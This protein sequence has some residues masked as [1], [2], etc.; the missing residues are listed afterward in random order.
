MKLTLN[1]NLMLTPYTKTRE[2]EQK[3]VATGFS[4]TSQKVGVEP[5]TLLV[6]ASIKICDNVVR[7]LK[8]GDKIYFKEATLFTQK[9]AREVFTTDDFPEGFIIANV[10]DA[11]YFE[12][13]DG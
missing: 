9:W 5:L 2:L 12:E 11:L 13:V 6:D 7:Q 3:Q 1:K 10:D 8:A 4:I